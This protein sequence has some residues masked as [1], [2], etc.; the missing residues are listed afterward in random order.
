MPSDRA[1]KRA[2]RDLQ[3]GDF[4]S[5]RRR[6]LSRIHAGGF[7]EEVCRRIAKISMDMKDPIEAGRWLFLVPCSEPRELECIN[8]F[9][10]SCGEL[11]EQ[12]LAC[13][14][15]CMTTLPPDRL[16]AA[17]AARLA[18]C[19]TAPKTSS[20]FK[21]KIYV[22]RPWAGLGCMAA[23]IVIVLLAAFGLFTLIGI[24]IG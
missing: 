21:E 20:S 11:R 4:G 18:A 7:D 14:P 8:D 22:G 15:R 10:R 1:I 17:A 6:L 19:P 16:P 24:L 12:V 5:A 9:T 13:L 23:V 2:E 3:A